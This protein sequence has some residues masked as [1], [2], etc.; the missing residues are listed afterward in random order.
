MPRRQN[1]RRRPLD[2]LVDGTWPDAR[3]DSSIAAE[4]AQVFAKRLREAAGDQ[5]L[6]EIGRRSDLDPMTIRALLRGESWPDMVSVAKL[7]GA[8]RVLLWPRDAERRRILRDVLGEDPETQREVED[9]QLVDAAEAVNAAWAAR[10]G[11]SYPN[12]L[13][14]DGRA[15]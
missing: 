9:R 14:D 4:Y 5:S 13:P 7:E 15:R 8:Y 10:F 3:L 12:R 11:T 2:Y 1:T 6:R